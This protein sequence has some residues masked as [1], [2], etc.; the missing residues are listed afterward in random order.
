MN[1]NFSNNIKCVDK[2]PVWR[3]LCDYARYCVLKERYVFEGCRVLLIINCSQIIS[4][5]A[6]LANKEEGPMIFN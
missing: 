4:L 1:V 5:C 3:L 2:R 6:L